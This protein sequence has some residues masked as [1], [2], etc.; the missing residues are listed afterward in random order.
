[1]WATVIRLL[2]DLEAEREAAETG[3][4]WEADPVAP[5]Q[6]TCSMDAPPY[7]LSLMSLSNS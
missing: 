5:M 4:P 6:Q 3:D 1:M 7:S 2:T